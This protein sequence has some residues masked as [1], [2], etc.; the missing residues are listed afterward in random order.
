M[1]TI[2]TTTQVQLTTITLNLSEPPPPNFNIVPS[3]LSFNYTIF[4]EVTRKYHS[5][6]THTGFS[7]YQNHPM[8]PKITNSSQ[9]DSRRLAVVHPRQKN[10]TEPRIWVF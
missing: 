4:N 10:H 3:N 7:F 2:S 9:I 1:L 5:L 8:M 6:T